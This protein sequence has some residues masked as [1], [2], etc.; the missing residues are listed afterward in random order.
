[1]IPT[2]RE[3]ARHRRIISEQRERL[4]RRLGVGRGIPYV[5]R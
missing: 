3:E 4:A 5:S 2:P 1:M